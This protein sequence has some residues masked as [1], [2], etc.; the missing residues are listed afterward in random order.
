[1]KTLTL[2]LI[3]TIGIIITQTGCNNPSD[4][5]C[6]RYIKCTSGYLEKI[7][8]KYYCS[9]CGKDEAMKPDNWKEDTEQFMEEPLDISDEELKDMQIIH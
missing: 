7:D 4:A 3:L 8:G 6:L 9:Y 1:M 2:F 5:T